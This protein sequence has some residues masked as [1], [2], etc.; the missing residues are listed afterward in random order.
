MH[1]ITWM[2]LNSIILYCMIPFIQLSRIAE[3]EISFPRAGGGGNGE[4]MPMA[5]CLFLGE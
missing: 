4:L 3:S 5:T 1:A 2:N